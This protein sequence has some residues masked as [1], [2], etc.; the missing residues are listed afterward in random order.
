MH[1]KEQHFHIG[2]AGKQVSKTKASWKFISPAPRVS[3]PAAR[4]SGMTCHSP[5]PPFPSRWAKVSLWV[6]RQCLRNP[7]CGNFCVL[8][9][10]PPIFS[11]SSGPVPAMQLLSRPYVGSTFPEALA[12]SCTF[13]TWA[14]T[15]SSGT[16]SL[17]RENS[18]VKNHTE[19]VTLVEFNG[20]LK[21]TIFSDQCAG[22]SCDKENSQIRKFI[23]FTLGS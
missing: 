22:R 7:L 20:K 21:I 1:P 23:P 5:Y 9:D 15:S 12:A 2:R 3:N 16:S 6:R 11:G 14:S 19:N 13:F 18:S 17:T 8:T 10:N 4:R